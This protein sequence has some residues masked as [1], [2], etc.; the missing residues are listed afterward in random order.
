MHEHYNEEGCM[1]L[2]IFCM[3]NFVEDYKKLKAKALKT[4]LQ[5][6]ISKASLERELL[7]KNWLLKYIDVDM[8]YI[9]ENVDRILEG[10]KV[11][12]V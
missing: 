11:E 4:N 3:E 5:E 9:L 6:D 10:Q 1:S 7:Q 2:A 8:E 12:F